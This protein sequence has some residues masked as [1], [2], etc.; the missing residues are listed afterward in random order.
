MIQILEKLS[1]PDI[2]SDMQLPQIILSALISL[3]IRA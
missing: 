1:V 2:E 3:S